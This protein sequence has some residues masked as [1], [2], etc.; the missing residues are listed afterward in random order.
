MEIKSR[1]EILQEDIKDLY[2]RIKKEKELKENRIITSES[3]MFEKVYRFE[4]AS[5]KNYSDYRKLID[6]LRKLTDTLHR[7]PKQNNAIMKIHFYYNLY[8]SLN[9]EINE[10]HKLMKDSLDKEETGQY[11]CLN[12][13]YLKLI[14]IIDSLERDMPEMNNDK[15]VKEYLK[16]NGFKTW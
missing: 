10:C 15:T 4:N 9:C 1:Q 16:I 13:S 5:E 2:F 12:D 6:S 3:N 7:L 11:R 8:E 14:E